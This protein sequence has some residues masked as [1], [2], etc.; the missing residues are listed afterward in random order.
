MKTLKKKSTRRLSSHKAVSWN[1]YGPLRTWPAGSWNLGD[2][3]NPKPQPRQ[4]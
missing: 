1:Y 3:Y 2:F 4:P